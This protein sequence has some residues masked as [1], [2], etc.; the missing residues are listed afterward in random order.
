MASDWKSLVD[1]LLQDAQNAGKF[2]NLPKTGQPLKIDDDPNTPSDMKLAHKILKENN[3]A[4]EWMML[5][6]DVDALRERLLDNMR[7]G[8]RAYRGAMADADRSADSFERRQRAETTLNRAKQA[9]GQAAEK[10]NREILRYNL[11]VPPAIAQKPLIDVE[12]ELDRL[13]H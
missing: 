6:K 9:W 11:K 13:L 8:A 4:P 12:H 1:Q 10:L 5:G 2:D 7:K 3:F